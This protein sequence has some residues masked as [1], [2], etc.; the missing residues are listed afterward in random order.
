MSRW[1]ESGCRC[2]DVTIVS[3]IPWCNYC[4]TLLVLEDIPPPTAESVPPLPQMQSR[5]KMNLTWPSV[6]RYTTC[7]PSD[8]SPLVHPSTFGPTGETHAKNQNQAS[9][10]R[11]GKGAFPEITAAHQIR[12]LRLTPSETDGPVHAYLELAHLGSSSTPAYEALSYTW[13]D[14]FGDL[15]R[16]SPIFIGPYWD[17]IY[18]TRNCEMALRRI[19]HKTVDRLLWVDSLCIN[20]DDPDEK[21]HQVGLMREIYSAASRV[22]VY[23]GEA[24]E[25]SNTALSILKA[26]AAE[27]LL[28]DRNPMIDPKHRLALQS[29]FQRPLFSRLW[30]ASERLLAHHLEIICGRDSVLW[31]NWPSVPVLAKVSGSSWLFD[32]NARNEFA[33]QDLLSALLKFSLYKCSDPRDKVFGVLGLTPDGLIKPDYSLHSEGVY[34]G[35]TAYLLKHCRVFDVLALAGCGNKKFNLP[36]WVPD[37]SQ[38]LVQQFPEDVFALEEELEKDDVFRDMYLQMAITF[39]SPTP[40]ELELQVD[41]YIGWLQTR[42]VKILDISGKMHRDRRGT[43][44]VV[45]LGQRGNLAI[46][47]RDKTYQCG[48]D[49]LFLLEGWSRPVILRSDP[50]TGSYLFVSVCA[51]LF[52]PPTSGLWLASYNL[53]RQHNER[54]VRVSS[55]SHEENEII[56]SFHSELMD[57]CQLHPTSISID[58]ISDSLVKSRI[59]DLGLLFLTNLWKLES[60]LQNQWNQLNQRLGWMFHDQIAAW[61]LLQDMSQSNED[62]RYG[63]GKVSFHESEISLFEEYCGIKFPISYRWDLARFCWSFIRSPY[64]GPASFENAW[65]PIYSQLKSHLSQLQTW[66]EVTE[67]LMKVLTY[68]QMALS[69]SWVHF[70]GANLPEKWFGRWRRFSAAMESGPLA[71]VH[72]AL[73]VDCFWDWS[74]FE[75]SLRLRERI[76]NQGMPQQLDAKVNDNIAVLLGMKTLGLELDQYRTIRIM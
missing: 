30:P 66:A 54:E 23:L 74:E 64:T 62:Q 58:S 44:I 75:D 43:I 20:Q 24:S 1:H 59:F 55:L 8:Q 76:W 35:I 15:T 9:K 42:A 72:Q 46:C 65:S 45:A 14:E 29:L 69:K 50:E 57:L 48:M 53:L 10:T 6:V 56:Q 26:A 68:S 18:L 12:L 13:A 11:G 2:P 4:S 7:C 28:P 34:T 5:A 25:D 16:Q 38:D 63:N 47:F 17:V 3:G 71:T 51:L 21:S 39:N 36:T 37:W 61:K 73:D 19:R 32:R 31:L 27:P 49:S 33:G 22:I 41:T 60:R 40:L 67:Q 52:G 70:P